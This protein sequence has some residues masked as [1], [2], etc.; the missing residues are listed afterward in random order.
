MCN[1]FNFLHRLIPSKRVQSWLVRL[2]FSSCPRCQGDEEADAVLEKV[3]AAP[4]WIAEQES[5][6]PHIRAQIREREERADKAPG[7]PGFPLRVKWQ[8]AAAIFVLA[9][10]IGLS[11]IIW[12]PLIRKS[13]EVS[14]VEAREIPRLQIKYAEVK[15]EKATPYI[16]Q[17]PRGSFIWFD[18]SRKSGG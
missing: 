6:W 9:L 1:L 11:T 2:H 17:T 7:K 4:P 5:L 15:G 3:A 12:H 13:P 14:M 10:A 18:Q 16:Y 8:W